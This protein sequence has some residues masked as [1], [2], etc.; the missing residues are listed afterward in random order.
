[1]KS[2][3]RIFKFFV[4]IAFACSHAFIQPTDQPKNI[5]KTTEPSTRTKKTKTRKRKPV[6]SKARFK[7][8]LKICGVLA[9]ICISFYSLPKLIDRI[10][11]SCCRQDFDDSEPVGFQYCH[12]EG[13]PEKTL[14]AKKH[15][16]FKGA[17]C[18][19]FL[20]SDSGDEDYPEM[21]LTFVVQPSYWASEDSRVEF[22][23]HVNE[24][25][26]GKSQETYVVMDDDK[27]AKLA[28][29]GGEYQIRALL[30]Y[31]FL[32]PYCRHGSWHDLYKT[33]LKDPGKWYLNFRG[34]D[35]CA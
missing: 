1:M 20:I 18:L 34:K 2:S 15:P 28:D 35:Q 17:L 22:S 16:N 11:L 13:V 21:V 24:L 27:L 10:L 25:F 8:A 19:G 4:F 3:S 7:K 32:L 31:S 6:I 26:E 29:F 9:F 30:P 23:K 5:I 12:L 33:H 14:F